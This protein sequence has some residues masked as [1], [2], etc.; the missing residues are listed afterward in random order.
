MA[1]KR[2]SSGITV[3]FKNVVNPTFVSPDAIL[4]LVNK[5]EIFHGDLYLWLPI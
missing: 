4:K 1:A 5:S 2:L 3:D